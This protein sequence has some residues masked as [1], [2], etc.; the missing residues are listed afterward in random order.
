MLPLELPA[1]SAHLNIGPRAGL[2]G[3]AHSPGAYRIEGMHA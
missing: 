1:E 3:S 2:F